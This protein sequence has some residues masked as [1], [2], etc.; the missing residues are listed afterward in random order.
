VDV[1]GYKLFYECRGLGSPTVILEAGGDAD[2]SAWS[3]VVAGVEGTARVCVYDRAGLGRSDG[4]PAPRTYADMT[5]DLETLLEKARIEGPY[6]LV[7]WSMGGN[8]VRLYASRHPQDVVGMV[9]VDSAHPD[10]AARLLAALP[11]Q[12][13]DETEAIAFLRQWFTWM[14]DSGEA[15]LEDPEGLDTRTSTQQMQAVGTLSDLP[16][17]V[18]T[19]NP[20]E[21]G[22]GYAAFAAMDPFP[23]E[24]DARLRQIWQDLQRDLAGLSS[25]S[26]QVFARGGHMIPIDEP[27]LVVEAILQIIDEVH[28]P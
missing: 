1:G 14:N 25:S 9:L 3:R 12:T 8:L 18:I 10:M 24:T 4:A 17:V 28:R 7:G 20:A 22:M 21:V 5:E 6:V 15:Y 27:Q 19:Q 11:P 2:S 23:Q 16:L 13:P 26:S